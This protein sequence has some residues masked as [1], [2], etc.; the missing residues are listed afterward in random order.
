MEK[1]KVIIDCDP[2]Y[3]DAVAL[4]LAAGNPNIEVLAI[5][6]VAGNQ[7]LEKVTRNAL[8]IAKLARL[9]EVTVAAGAARPLLRDQVVVA[10]N[11]HG[12]S[13][14]DG[15]TLPEAEYRVDPRCAAQVIV[16]TIMREPEKTVTLVPIGP[17]TN[18]ALAARLEPRIV[19]RVKEVVLMGGGYHIG[20]VKPM[21]EFNI[22]NDPEAAYIVFEEK[23]PIVMVGLDL[24]YQALAT[25]DVKE[26]IARID[27][28]C[29][30]FLTQVL[31]RFSENYKRSKGFDEPPVHDPC[32]IAYVIDPSIIQVRKAP[33]HVEYR[34]QFT[35]G[36][37]VTDLRKPAPSDCH[38]AV[39]THLA[40]ER[41]WN[42]IIEAVKNQ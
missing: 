3:D 2:G 24:T 22:E 10:A 37:T 29:A 14:L 25:K 9:E 40:R 31:T 33:V 26:K 39:A 11:I 20:N 6:T 27:T 7:T 38:T 42:L 28:P 21:A 16:D 13:G 34:G 32:A 12:E 8:R 18:I 30:Q 15:T 36:M 23:W 35:S 1:R 5:T 41:F 4:L 19:D 17:L